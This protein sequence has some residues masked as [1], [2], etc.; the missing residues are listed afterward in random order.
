[1]TNPSQKIEQ[2]DWSRLA[3]DLAKHGF[4][5]TGK[6]L[7]AADCNELSRMFSDDERFR[8]TVDM[9]P[10]RYGEGRYRYFAAP[11]PALV[12]DLRDRLY[13]CLAPI[14]NTMMADLRRETRYPATLAQ[15]LQQCAK[16]GQTKPTPLLLHYDTGGYNRLHRDLYGEL[17]FPLQAVCLLS[18]E[19]GFE[20]GE[21][22]LV[23]QQPRAQSI[24]RA[25]SLRRGE[26]LIFPVAERPVAGSR[27]FFT[28]QMRHGV[29]QVLAGERTTL[30]I[31]FHNA[32]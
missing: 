23:E 32:A 1:M 21:F 16:A 20:G 25:I 17:K 6:I 18:R 30:G 12:T 4:A 9:G 7:S 13:T 5:R 24:G 22:L 8:S 26:F 19:D 14:A 11:L 28:A 3:S 29:S 2:Q 31:I 27:G 10:R 15:Y